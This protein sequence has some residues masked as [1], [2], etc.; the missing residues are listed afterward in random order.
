MG[1]KTTSPLS[2][3]LPPPVTVRALCSFR[4][5]YNAAVTC[6]RCLTTSLLQTPSN[7]H[8]L[9][10][11]S[12]VHNVKLA[13][14]ASCAKRTTCNRGVEEEQSSTGQGSGH[15]CSSHGCSVT[16]TGQEWGWKAQAALWWAPLGWSHL[17]LP[18]KLPSR[19]PWWLQ[20]CSS[21]GA[22]EARMLFQP[23]F[24]LCCS[25]A[26]STYSINIWSSLVPSWASGFWGTL[27][28]GVP[29]LIMD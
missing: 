8:L 14:K 10:Q 4:E 11:G 12:H 1:S 18:G 3:F 13:A 29:W 21:S 28:Q 7:Q 22:W 19:E 26:D 17:A 2:A 16:A 15:F 5:Y 6:T 9:W 23:V 25:S 27:W 20:V 24:I